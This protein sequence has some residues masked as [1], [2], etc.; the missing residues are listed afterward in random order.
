MG[1]RT[2]A[3]LGDTDYARLRQS[4]DE[5]RPRAELGCPWGVGYH[6]TALQVVVRDEA[7]R[8]RALEDDDLQIRIQV[9]RI[10]EDVE[11]GEHLRVVE[12]IGGVDNR[13]QISRCEL[14]DGDDVAFDQR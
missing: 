4:G 9:D 11:F 12:V 5:S 8:A 10:H 3:R 14:R 6:L 1:P 13:Q 7:V 2:T